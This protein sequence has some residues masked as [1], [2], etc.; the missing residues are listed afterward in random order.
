MPGTPIH[1][2]TLTGPV[3]HDPA[4]GIFDWN[5]EDT[6][7]GEFRATTV[8]SYLITYFEP[9]EPGQRG[10]VQVHFGRDIQ[11]ASTNRARDV[12][13]HF[14][15]MIAKDPDNYVML[16]IPTIWHSGKRR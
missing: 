3:I 16:T 11:F 4:N 9:R 10:C 6:P 12:A 7:H 15:E 1:D 5:G 2:L 13:E 8:G 14:A